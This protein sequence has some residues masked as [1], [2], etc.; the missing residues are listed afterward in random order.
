M[1]FM[2]VFPP[3]NF[4]IAVELPTLVV[5]NVMCGTHARLWVMARSI[6]FS[7]KPKLKNYSST[8]FWLLFD[9]RLPICNK[10]YIKQM[11]LDAMEWMSNSIFWTVEISTENNIHAC[12]NCQVNFVS[13]L[14]EERNNSSVRAKKVTLFL[15]SEYR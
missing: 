5:P 11:W 10:E 15:E 3:N 2:F 13:F 12:H 14:R 1:W 9:Y 6:Y 8:H 4:N 7:F